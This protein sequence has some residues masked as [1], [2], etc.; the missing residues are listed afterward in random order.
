[1]KRFRIVNRESGI[2]S[3]ERF[4]AVMDPC[5]RDL[6]SFGSCGGKRLICGGPDAH[7]VLTFRAIAFG[8]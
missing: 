4:F 3:F 1:V 7:K 6:P 8:S 5:V 2:Y